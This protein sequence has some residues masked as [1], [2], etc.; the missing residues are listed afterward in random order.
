ME[1]CTYNAKFTKVPNDKIFNKGFLGISVGQNYHEGQIFEATLELVNDRLLNCTIGVCDTLQRYTMATMSNTTDVDIMR[2]PS[3]ELGNQWIERN[4]ALFEQYFNITYKIK[5][6]DDWIAKT[7]Y[8]TYKKELDDLYNK[9]KAF[10]ALIDS[11][12]KHFNEK[13]VARGYKFDKEVGQHNSREYL[14]EE[15]AVCC[16]CYDEKYDVEISVYSRNE[17]VNYVLSKIKGEKQDFYKPITVKYKKQLIVEDPASKEA[18]VNILDILP[19]HIYWIDE[20]KKLLGCNKKMSDS[21]GIKHRDFFLNGNASKVTD[22]VPENIQKNDLQVMQT[23]ELCVFEEYA[24][25]HGKQKCFLSH[26]IPILDKN[27]V[28]G[29][30]GVSLDITEQ[31]KLEKRLVK[32]TT[33]L[34]SALLSKNEFLNTLSHEIRIPTHVINSIAKEVQSNLFHFSREEIKGYFDML[35]QNSDRLVTLVQNLLELAKSEQHSINYVFEEKNI[36]NV[37]KRT[38]EEFSCVGHILLNT[39]YDKIITKIDSIKISQVLRNLFDNAIKYGEKGKD[40]IVKASTSQKTAI[41]TIQNKGE[42]I[43]QH[44]MKKVFEPFFR[45]SNKTKA[46]GTGLG[47]SICKKIVQSHGGSIW[48]EAKAGWVSMVFRIPIS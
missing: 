3:K 23:K 16:I 47:L 1:K 35:A 20:N 43:P 17:L 36:I 25:V 24:Q 15:Y 12:V 2:I 19:G 40:I 21:L 33:A 6:W 18:L 48:I 32:K 44:E 9:D 10:K 4:T 14:L 38:I 11:N 26:K 34:Q 31:K 8:L 29:L 13:L 5:R 37:I 42:S 45:G 22:T 41:I 39:E 7:N 27:Q 28:K 30:V 46:N